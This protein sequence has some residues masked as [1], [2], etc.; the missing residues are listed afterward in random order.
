MVSFGPK[1]FPT[2]GSG[3]FRRVNSRRV[4]ASI[5]AL[6]ALL[7]CAPSFAQGFI[8][9]GDFSIAASSSAGKVTVRLNGSISNSYGT[10]SAPM[11]L[12]VS[13]RPT[14]GRG[15]SLL[16]ARGPTL[17]SIPPGGLLSNVVHENLPFLSVPPAGPYNVDLELYEQCP[18]FAGCFRIVWRH[19][20]TFNFPI[21]TLASAASSNY[22]DMWWNP[23]E[24]GWGLAILDHETQLFGIWYTYDASGRPK[25]FTIPGG[26]LSSDRRHFTG[27]L[28]STT[29]PSFT[30]STF[31][32]ASVAVAKVG[33]ASFDFSP[34]GVT[35][36]MAVFNYTLN[37]ISGSKQIQRQPFG[38]SA[39]NWGVDNTDLWWNANE[40]G[41]G[42]SLIQHG[43]TA[44]GVFFLYDTDGQ[45][46]WVVMPGGTFYGSRF[47]GP[48]FTT[49]GPAFSAVPFN[50]AAV[51]VTPAGSASFNFAPSVISALAGA[52]LACNAS[53]ELNLR[54]TSWNKCIDPQTFGR[55]RRPGNRV[56][57][58]PLAMQPFI[59][60]V[61]S[62]QRIARGDGGSPPYH[63][64]SDTFANGAPPFGLT[65]ATDLDTN[66]GIL[67]GT[68]SVEGVFTFGVCVV[69]LGGNQSCAPNQAI[70]N[71]NIGISP[72]SAA[73]PAGGANG[74][75]SVT[76]RFGCEWEASDSEA[77]ITLTVS[78]ADGT[79]NYSAAAN[80]GAQRTGAIRVGTRASAQTFV[81]T[82]AAGISS[83]GNCSYRICTAG[84]ASTGGL[85]PVPG[86]PCGCLQDPTDT[87]CT[88][89]RPRVELG[90]TCLA[91]GTRFGCP[92][93]TVC[94]ANVS[95]TSGVCMTNAEFN[96]TMCPR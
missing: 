17:P 14:H 30:A 28:Y 44:F 39:P 46:L 53:F 33:T 70:V 83:G 11:Y 77:W 5:A 4:L 59:V 12:V 13:L 6:I 74:V 64:L 76:P 34:P 63:F 27:D 3:I 81:L 90:Q 20:D 87:A 54:G 16:L 29:G 25:W 23:L 47:S 72:A 94:G 8:F 32:P 71:C 41:W 18:G 61:R 1:V 37:G 48:V 67:S 89:S 49:R 43:S 56:A 57:I 79:V 84:T 75:F 19:Q 85:F 42:V 93:G 26:T 96:A 2:R 82:Q 62:S 66:F 21:E 65:I 60:G 36:G 45:P 24:S 50:P 69:D 10:A 51:N 58:T 68:P 7:G 91:P 40:S 15:G 55:P 95:G 92:A 22:S 9:T 80:T 52:K 88:P 31:N 38:T 86:T 73:V 78:R 35:S